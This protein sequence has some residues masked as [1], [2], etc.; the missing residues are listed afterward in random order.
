MLDKTTP[1]VHNLHYTCSK[2][3]TGNDLIPAAAWRPVKIA[4]ISQYGREF[5]KEDS[6]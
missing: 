1:I 6:K 2:G 5:Y 4:V 3:A